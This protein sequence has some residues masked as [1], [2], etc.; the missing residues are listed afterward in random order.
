MRR[1]A[2][3]SCRASRVGSVDRACA[4]AWQPS[5]AGVLRRVGVV[6]SETRLSRRGFMAVPPEYFPLF[7]IQVV[8]GRAFTSREADE[9]AAVALSVR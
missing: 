7:D 3:G 1:F 6:P 8:Q 5:L 9:G 4:A 2:R